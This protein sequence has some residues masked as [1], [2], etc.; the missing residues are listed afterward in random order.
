MESTPYEGHSLS[1]LRRVEEFERVDEIIE[2]FD[3]AKLIDDG[4]DNEQLS[5]H[6]TE[7]L[8]A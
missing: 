2:N 1:M 5:V 4:A 6:E 3:L 7:S 8:F